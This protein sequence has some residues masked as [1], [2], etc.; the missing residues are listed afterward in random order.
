MVIALLLES[1][2]MALRSVAGIEATRGVSR[3]CSE[4]TWEERGQRC[5]AGCDIETKVREFD[6]IGCRVRVSQGHEMLSSDQ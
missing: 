3:K 6:G 4:K 5:N 1:L 2:L